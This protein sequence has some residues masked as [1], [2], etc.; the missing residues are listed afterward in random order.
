MKEKLTPFYAG[1]PVM[2][3]VYER[4]LK[5]RMTA[6][7]AYWDGRYWG[8]Y[9]QTSIEVAASNK[10]FRSEFQGGHLYRGLAKPA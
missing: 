5:H 2:A 9:H 8:G 10:R 7:Y 1:N 6:V 4:M 3:G